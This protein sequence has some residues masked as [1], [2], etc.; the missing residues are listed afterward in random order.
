MVIGIIIEEMVKHDKNG[1]NTRNVYFLKMVL[2]KMVN[3][4]EKIKWS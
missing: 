3:M 4:A 1:N 2:R